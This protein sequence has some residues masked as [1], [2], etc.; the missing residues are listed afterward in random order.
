MWLCQPRHLSPAIQARQVDS[1][2]L[3]SD[4]LLNGRGLG[5]LFSIKYE[6]RSL[7]EEIFGRAVGIAMSCHLLKVVAVAI[8]YGEGHGLRKL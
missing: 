4:K 8:F 7:S 2:Q 6:E 5:L 1:I 3:K